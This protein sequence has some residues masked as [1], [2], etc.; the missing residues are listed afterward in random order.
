MPEFVKGTPARAGWYSRGVG[1]PSDNLTVVLRRRLRA[2]AA[3]GIV[4]AA[5]MAAGGAAAVLLSAAP[6]AAATPAP[7]TAHARAAGRTWA[8]HTPVPI[9]MYHHVQSGLAGSKLMYVSLRQ[10]ENQLSYL[11]GHGYHPITMARV[12]E[13]WN[14]GAALPLRPVVLA[15]DDGY[16]D[17]YTNA[18]RILRRRHWPAVLNLVVHRGTTLTDAKVRRM[19]S[20]G[21]EIGSHTMDHKVLTKLSPG[22]LRDQLTESRR[23]LRK[24]FRQPVDFF[25]YPY[26]EFNGR[27][28]RAVERAG[29]LAATEVKYGAATPYRRWAMK[30]IAVWWGEPLSKFGQRMR[31][32]VRQAR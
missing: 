28:E 5:L 20:W 13:A 26:G 8:D 2:A 31:D 32:A 14:G 29:Y 11:R 7:S 23:I 10:F 3:C 27:V 21:W 24:E 19:V 17:Q 1:A 6:P 9:L 16:I 4:A 15:F 30:R 18:A 22:A 25:C 12:W